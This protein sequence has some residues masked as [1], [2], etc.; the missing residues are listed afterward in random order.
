MCKLSL[1]WQFASLATLVAVLLFA[2]SSAS[3][4][5][6]PANDRVLHVFL[7]GNNDGIEPVGNVVLD[8][9][10]NVYGATTFGGNGGTLCFGGSCGTVYQLVPPVTPGSAWTENILYN[11]TGVNN[12]QD[13]ELPNGGLAIDP[14]GNLY[15]VAAYGGTGGCVLFGGV[16]GCGIVYQL[17]PP[18]APDGAWTEATIY[19]FQGGADGQLPS[20]SLTLD[21]SGNLYGATTYGGG[22]GSCNEPYYQNCGT[23]FELTPPS[24]R[25]GAW[26]EKVLYS[27]KSGT[28][29]AIP[30]GGLV[31]DK[32]G[33]LYGTTLV[34]GNE[35]CSSS[36][37]V[38]CGTVFE[39][40]PVGARP[41]AW[42]ETVLYRFRS[43]GQSDEKDGAGPNPGLVIAADGSLY[44]TTTGGGTTEEGTIFS[45]SP[46]SRA[47]GIW[48]ETVVR[49]FGGLVGAL[50]MA[51]L[52]LRGGILYGTTFEGG[53]YEAGTVFFLKSSA[54]PSDDGG[55]A[56]VCDFP[57]GNQAA[58]PEGELTFDSTG[59]MYGTT[60]AYD[61]NISG[62]VF[63]ISPQNLR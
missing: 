46:P 6:A 25:G 59:A 29:G 48:R 7:G 10:G 34:G 54:S 1:T 28:D 2:G 45:L 27:F 35:T 52:V 51:G 17:T 63:R 60:M 12:N 53:G 14:S 55:F 5:Y 38:G 23:I 26:T 44:G 47:N 31:L 50:P 24:T 56:A 37:G 42:I 21:V 20:G 15:G 43:E 57:T 19:S 4:N 32:H 16:A 9:N 11:F 62:T 13:G 61:T 3:Q 30:F 41:G 40:Q 18:A 58:E 33:I 8:A 22:F 39:L 36:W 49:N